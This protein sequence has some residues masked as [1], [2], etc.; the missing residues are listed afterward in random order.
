MLRGRA[1]SGKLESRQIGKCP[2]RDVSLAR[3]PHL[4]PEDA[5]HPTERPEPPAPH[6][7]GPFVSHPAGADRPPRVAA[8]AST[9]EAKRTPARRP[10]LG[11]R[12]RRADPRPGRDCAVRVLEA[13]RDALTDAEPTTRC[14]GGNR[15]RRRR[16]PCTTCPPPSPR[17]RSARARASSSCCTPLLSP[18]PLTG[19]TA[20]LVAAS[21]TGKTTASVTLGRSFA[22]VTDETC[23]HH[24][25]RCRAALPQAPVD[26][27]R[28]TPEEADRAVG[29]RAAPD[30]A[31][32]PPGRPARD[33]ARSAS[34]RAA[35]TVEPLETVDAI[36]AIAPAVVHTCPAWTSRSTAWPS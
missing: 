9:D 22:Y 32:V 26:H 16:A 35:P 23:S 28:R 29:A 4:E 5:L 1:V 12:S 3:C 33:R 21:G 6:A 14:G 17:P 8:M 11:L 10:R 20:V 27:R 18:I 7:G 13:W 2:R 34:I 30:R 24:P 36:A 25:R 31:G 19:R 15:V